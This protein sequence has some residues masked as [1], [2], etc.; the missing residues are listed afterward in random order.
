MKKLN[1]ENCLIPPYEFLLFSQ[2]NLLLTLPNVD[3]ISPIISNNYGMLPSYPP[4]YM[5]LMIELW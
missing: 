5:S 4:S 1:V 3:C 2:D